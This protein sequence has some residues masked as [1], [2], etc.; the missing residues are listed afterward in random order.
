MSLVKEI[1]DV[2]AA[3]ATVAAYNGITFRAEWPDQ[4]SSGTRV[5]ATQV[6][7]SRESALAQANQ[8][9][10]ARIQIDC[11]ADNYSTVKA[12]AEDVSDALHGYEGA[13]GPPRS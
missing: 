11:F 8:L 7:G 10:R 13:A 6:S 3:D 2:V 9:R 4:D 12:L 5:V 1:L